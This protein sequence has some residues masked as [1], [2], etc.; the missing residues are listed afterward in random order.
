MAFQLAAQT[1]TG[2]FGGLARRA[3]NFTLLSLGFSVSG[4]VGPLAAGF[5]IDH[6]GFRA[7]FALFAVVP[8]IPLAVLANRRFELPAAG[9]AKPPRRSMAECSR[10]CATGRCAGCLR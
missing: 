6:F 4:F 2:E 5:A 7:A 9:T 8:L 3:R 1:A 10:C